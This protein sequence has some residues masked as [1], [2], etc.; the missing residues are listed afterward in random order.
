ML[1]APRLISSAGTSSPMPTS[2]QS[3]PKQ[4]DT[5]RPKPTK[6][7]DASSIAKHFQRSPADFAWRYPFFRFS[8]VSKKFCKTARQLLRESIQ[9]AQLRSDIVCHQ[10]AYFE[11]HSTLETLGMNALIEYKLDETEENREED[12]RV[13]RKPQKHIDKFLDI[14]STWVSDV[15]CISRFRNLELLIMYYLNIL[16]ILKG[17]VT[18]TLI[19]Q[20][21]YG[22]TN[23]EEEMTCKEFRKFMRIAFAFNRKITLISS[24][25]H[26]LVVSEIDENHNRRRTESDVSNT[27]SRRNSSNDSTLLLHDQNT[28]NYGVVPT[29]YPSQHMPS[30]IW[31]LFLI[32]K[33]DV[34]TAMFV[35]LLS[36]ILFFCN[37]MLL[38]SLIQFTEQ[39]ERLMW[40]GV[41]L[42][43]TIFGSAELSSILLSHFLFLIRSVFRTPRVINETL[44]NYVANNVADIKRFKEDNEFEGKLTA[45]NCIPDAMTPE[46]VVSS[47]S[48]EHVYKV[49]LRMMIDIREAIAEKANRKNENPAS[50]DNTQAALNKLVA[51]MDGWFKLMKV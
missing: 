31:T 27:S 9:Q 38:K 46:N 6:I 7:V 18:E 25:A 1:F 36:D 20:G 30:I 17:D 10:L 22:V 47:S 11:L 2:A 45:E 26:T 16:N 43:F 4:P 23:M 44:E 40:Q 32:F 49:F 3:E 42:A 37:P 12:P 8:R 39:L 33:W 24:A 21:F 48:M 34:I 5:P 51:S 15:T 19:F 50:E 35:K 29:S 28:D 13:P 14:S 41:V